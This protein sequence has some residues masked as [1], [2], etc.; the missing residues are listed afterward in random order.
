[1]SGGM[2]IDPKELPLRHQEQLAAEIRGKLERFRKEEE[3][4]EELAEE[5][6]M[7]VIRNGEDYQ[8]GAAQMRLAILKELE[9]MTAKAVGVR[10]EALRDV[11]RMIRR[12]EVPRWKIRSWHSTGSWR[13]TASWIRTG[14]AEAAMRRTAY[15]VW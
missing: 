7:P 2:R 9:D 11:T 15:G 12:L 8:T 5:P 6:E 4:A 3:W 14:S 1:M 13:N 10:W